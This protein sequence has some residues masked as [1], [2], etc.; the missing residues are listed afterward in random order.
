[1]GRTPVSA[2]TTFTSSDGSQQR[3]SKDK[4]NP[5]SLDTLRRIA[6]RSLYWARPFRAGC[7]AMA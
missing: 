2:L 6:S 3:P 1:M 7:N 4:S 5:A